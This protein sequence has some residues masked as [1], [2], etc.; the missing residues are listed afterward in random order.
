MSNKEESQF[1]ENVESIT[2]VISSELSF[3]DGVAKLGKDTVL[4]TLPEDLDKK[5]FQASVNHLHDFDTALR[6][7]TLQSAR[8]QFVDHADL[9]KVTATAAFG[10][11]KWTA[12]VSREHEVRNPQSGEKSIVKGFVRG[13]FGLHVSSSDKAAVK[14]EASLLFADL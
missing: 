14:N 7:A 6:R 2:K 11:D 13:S 3:T 5:S 1:S 4:A 9:D 10:Y 8:Q 12:S